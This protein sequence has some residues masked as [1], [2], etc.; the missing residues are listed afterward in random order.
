MFAL[1]VFVMVDAVERHGLRDLIARPRSP[2][3]AT[4]K[5]GR[6]RGGISNIVNNLPATVISLPLIGG[7]AHRAYALLAGGGR[8]PPVS[9][10]P[11]RS[12]RSSGLA[13]ARS[14]EPQRQP[15]P[16]P[17][18]RRDPTVGLAAALVT[19]ELLR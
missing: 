10:P 14:K 15:A 4:R 11:G 19:L 3:S 1:G 17:R 5:I 18:D 8:Q 16:L 9:R 7:D 13:V 2:G 6:A 12:R